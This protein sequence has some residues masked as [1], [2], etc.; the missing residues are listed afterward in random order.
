MTMNWLPTTE[1]FMRRLRMQRLLLPVLLMMGAAWPG[2]APA[3]DCQRGA[4]YYERAKTA[5]DRQASIEWLQ[6]SIEACP[7]FNAWYMLGR[8][9]AAQGRLDQA[10]HAFSQ[11]RTAA[12]TARTEALALGRQGEVLSQAGQQHQALRT[13]ELA[14]QFHPPPAPDWL[15]TALR[16]AR[17]Q[18]YRE[19][20]AAADIAAWLDPG[21][22]IGESGRFAVRPAVNL[23]VHFEFDRADLNARGNRQVIELGRALS[24]VKLGQA[25][26]LLVGH[27]D[28]RG[29]RAYNQMLS[30]R[31]AYTV[32][33]ELERRF[34][35]LIGKLKTAGR[36]ETQLLYDGDDETDH[37]LNRRVKIS[38][39]SD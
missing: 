2:L 12:G 23:P 35:S 37:M 11:A 25:S 19:I 32:K 21:A 33:I 24:G 18:A 7:N 15:E 20:M 14:H 26:F 10:V 5:G 22:A 29:S 8:L 36:G 9:F 28:K 17:I 27:T 34:P 30:E 6:R 16:K 4:D 38:L 31:R 3:M 1:K 13:L 39:I